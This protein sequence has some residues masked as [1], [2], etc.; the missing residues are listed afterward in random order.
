MPYQ[1]CKIYNDGSHFIAIPHTT[2]PAAPK[3]YHP[4]EVIEVVDG[5]PQQQ[6]LNT[7]RCNIETALTALNGTNKVDSGESEAVETTLT[8]ETTPPATTR[9]ITRKQLFDELYEQC[10]DMKYK[11]K[12]EYIKSHMSQYFKSEEET[13]D[14]VDKHFKRKQRNLICRKVRLYR[15][16]SLQ[17]WDFFCTFTYDDKKHIEESFRKKLSDTLKKMCYRR[18]WKYIGVWERSPEKNRLHFHGLFIIPD[19]QMVGELMEVKDYSPV[20]E[21]K[22]KRHIRM[23]ILTKDSADRTSRK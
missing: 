3:R 22:C 7:D 17:S 16:A 18:K 20:K 19:G 8:D 15:K 4:E 23:R 12:K 10:K 9:K 5:L 11:G 21:R 13:R 6:Q 2:R 1:K 14:F